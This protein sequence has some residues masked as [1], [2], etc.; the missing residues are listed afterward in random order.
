MRAA[1]A[2]VAFGLLLAGCT[3]VGT[4]KSGGS[5]PVITLSLGTSDSRGAAQDP[6]IKHFV[7]AVA[8]QSDGRV[9]VRTSYEAG[10]EGGKFDQHVA[11]LVQDG[12]FDLGNVPARSWD[13]LEVEG[14]RALQTPF[15]VDSDDLV[16]RVVGGELAQLLLA[17]LDSTGVR[18]LALWPE[19]LRHPIGFGKPILTPAD[20]QGVQLQVPYSRDVHA[21]IQALG[22]EP[23]WLDGAD[24]NAG[25]AAGTLAGAESGADRSFGPP[26]IITADVTMYAKIDTLVV[27][28]RAW[29]RLPGSARKALASAAIATRDWLVKARPR[30]AQLL[31][32]ACVEG[33][34]VT[35]AGPAVVAELER[36]AE[37][38]RASMLAD[39]EVGPTI[40]KIE[41]LKADVPTPSTTTKECRS[42]APAA[43]IGTPIDPAVLDGTYRTTFTEQELREAGMDE[44]SIRS[45]AG[46]PWTITLA[47][48]HYSALED[49]CTGTY[50][51]SRMMVSFHFDPTVKCSGDWTA[52][53]KLTDDGVR[54]QDVQSGYAADRAIWG[55]HEWV[56]LR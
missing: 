27:N 22:S 47:G 14:L 48:G 6:A 19:T 28:D 41:A 46:A 16:D 3:L 30:E 23:V 29:D 49:D 50:E 45:N 33:K 40:R 43:D 35:L 5:G 18:G 39:P 21:T 24:L 12:T 51:V 13:D 34:G 11:R 52:H 10:A 15:L 32:T 2:A 44:Q 56:R 20:F 9:R 17:G 54:F 7:A 38:V 37:P 31:G 26:A 8:D 53:W 55:L 4:D 1:F 36:S 42:E 25:Y